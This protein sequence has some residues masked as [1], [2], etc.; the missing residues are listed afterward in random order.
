M[1]ET[2]GSP[3]TSARKSQEQW[4][5]SQASR[6]AFA[7]ERIA[8]WH[9]AAPATQVHQKSGM[10]TENRGKIK[11]AA[12]SKEKIRR[13]RQSMP[14]SKAHGKIRQNHPLRIIGKI[15]PA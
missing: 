2:N 3:D 10:E 9:D 14:D 15:R 13:A 12:E 1:S 7:Q 4:P 11:T 5:H 6:P 8:G